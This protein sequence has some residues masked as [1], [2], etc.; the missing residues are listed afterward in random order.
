MLDKMS[1]DHNTTILNTDYS[2]P[3]HDF[4][5]IFLQNKK[6]RDN[7]HHKWTVLYQVEVGNALAT[8]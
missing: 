4:V 8:M 7:H 6:L 3:L 5:H 1:H 2:L